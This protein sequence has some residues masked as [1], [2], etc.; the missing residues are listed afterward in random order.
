MS[1]S[2]DKEIKRLEQYCKG[3]GI[4]ISYKQRKTG[5]PEAD[6]NMDSNKITI[7]LHSR[8]TKTQIILN[9][10]H[11]LGHH[12]DFVYNNRKITDKVDRAWGKE[13]NNLPMSKKQRKVIYDDEVNASKFRSQIIHELNLKI[14]NDLLNMDID[15]DLFVYGYFYKHGM[16]PDVNTCNNKKNELKLK[17]NARRLK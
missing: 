7:Y 6:W 10:I 2:K 5:D 9:I 12:M 13:N 15:M 16:Y 11:E 3:L 4:E 17:Y 1:S 14:S 8:L